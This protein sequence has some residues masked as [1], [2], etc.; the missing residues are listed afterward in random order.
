MDVEAVQL[1][2]GDTV[3][4]NDKTTLI[5]RQTFAYHVS[6]LYEAWTQAEVIKLWFHPREGWTIDRAKI[7]LRVGGRYR[8][9]MTNDSRTRFIVEGS[10]LKVEPFCALSFSWTWPKEP[11]LGETKVEVTFEAKSENTQLCLIHSGFPSKEAKEDHEWGWKGCLSHLQS[12]L[13]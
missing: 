2:N 8:I 10:Y 12:I 11:L 1:Q 7:D 4:A 13:R 5:L 9:E 6:E 3:A